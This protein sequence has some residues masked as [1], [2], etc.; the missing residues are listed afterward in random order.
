MKELRKVVTLVKKRF[1]LPIIVIVFIISA[2]LFQYN[3]MKPKSNAESKEIIRIEIPVGS[4]VHSIA[5]LLEQKGV[6]KSSFAFRLYSKVNDLE[7]KYK[8]GIYDLDNSKDIKEIA[9]MLQYGKGFVEIVKFTIPEGFEVRMIVD[10]LVES[11]LGD[12]DKFYE[13]INDHPFD[14]D[15]LQNI[16]RKEE[17]LEGYLFPDTYEVYKNT[18]EQE[19]INK[20]LERF[21]HIFNEEYKKRVSELNMTVDEVITLASIIEREAK[22]DEERKIISSVFHNRLKKKMLLQSCATVQYVLKERKEVLLY[23]DLEVN[24]PYNTYKNPGLTPGPIASPGLKSIEAA[25]YPDE[26]DYLYF[27]AKND[28]THVFTKTFK[29]HIEAQNKLKK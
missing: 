11:G 4:N 16:S 15:F 22:V 9:S 25:L 18:S 26:T 13:I 21:D 1:V 29:E 20:M 14:Y 12:E 10:K 6:I 28:G 23:K 5:N 2:A 8:A 24:S 3:N 7:D 27:V 17:R 19:I